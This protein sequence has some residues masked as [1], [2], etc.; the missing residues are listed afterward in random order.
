MC[1]ERTEVG[2]SVGVVVERR[3]VAR[4]GGVAGQGAGRGDRAGI[5]LNGRAGVQR[6]CAARVADDVACQGQP[7]T[8]G[9]GQGHA[10][11]RHRAADAQGGVV[12]EGERASGGEASQ[13]ADG[14]GV[15]VERRRVARAGGVAGQDAGRGDRAGI[16]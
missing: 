14:I 11:A 1:A 7:V 8:C 5:L 15:A 3:R 10:A 9:R 2:D 13:C 4:A 6:H 12:G 16:L